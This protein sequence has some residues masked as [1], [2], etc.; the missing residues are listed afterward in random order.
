MI[1][2]RCMYSL[3]FSRQYYHYHNQ[4]DHKQNKN[5]LPDVGYM[6]LF[7]LNYQDNIFLIRSNILLFE[8]VQFFSLCLPISI[9]SIFLLTRKDVTLCHLYIQT[10]KHF[11]I[12][13]SAIYAKPINKEMQSSNEDALSGTLTTIICIQTLYIP[14]LL[15]IRFFYDLEQE[16]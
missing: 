11:N 13:C 3:S 12:Y 16:Q 9:N 15:H 14:F 8:E 2:F 10:K 4:V 6:S 1:N 5:Y 7:C